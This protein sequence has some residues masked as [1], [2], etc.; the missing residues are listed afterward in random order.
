MQIEGKVAVITGGASGLGEAT[1]RRFV[2]QGARVAIFDMNAERGNAIAAELGQQ[3]IYQ[4]VNVTDEASVKAGID[5][6]LAAFGAIHICSNYAGVADAA[7][8]IGKK[9]AFPLDLFQ[10]VININ[11]VGSF[12]VLRLVAEVMSRQ[13][14]LNADGARGVI[15]N[16]ASVA[17]YEGQVGQAAYSAS[18]GGIV[19]MTLPIARDLAAYGIRVNTIAPGLIHTP[20]CDS[21]PEETVAALAANVPFP[22]RLGKPD[23]VAQL[24]QSIVENDYLN[25]EVIRCD[26]AIRMQPR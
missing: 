22:S 20:M 26:G 9:G 13:E 1:V 4:S 21:L 2:A 7:K 3:V 17:A 25:G 14:P 6:T 11:L 5:A 19:G 10:K 18:K 8:T 12:N 15:I 16:T 24:A 23:E